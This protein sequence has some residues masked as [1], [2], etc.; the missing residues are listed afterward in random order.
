MWSFVNPCKLPRWIDIPRRIDLY[1]GKFP[2]S[3]MNQ[4]IKAVQHGSRVSPTVPPLA[5]HKKVH[6][7]RCSAASLVSLVRL[8]ASLQI[9]KAPRVIWFWDSH[10]K[11][12]YQSWDSGWFFCLHA[13][14][15]VPVYY[16]AGNVH[17]RW[18]QQTRQVETVHWRS[19]SHNW[20]PWFSVAC[21]S[22]RTRVKCHWQGI[23]ICPQLDKS[24]C[25]EA[26]I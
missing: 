6:A 3:Q 9:R 22:S 17:W 23:K 12:H 24:L 19:S 5:P 8:I 10:G 4:C 21:T 16:T 14:P 25:M 11:H 13:L 15:V 20:R 18:E 2:C 26:L 1:P 7:C